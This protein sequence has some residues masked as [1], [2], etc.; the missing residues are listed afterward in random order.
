MVIYNNSIY[1]S[2]M[3]SLDAAALANSGKT[4]TYWKVHIFVDNMHIWLIEIEV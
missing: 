1:I 3:G 4:V 2:T